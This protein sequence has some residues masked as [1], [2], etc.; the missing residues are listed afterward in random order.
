MSLV[1]GLAALLLCC[2]PPMQFL[3]GASAIITAILSRKERFSVKAR[4]ALILGSISIL[5]SIIVFTQY[6][7]AMRLMSDPANAA[8]VKEVTRYYEEI[9][10]SFQTQ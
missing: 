4:I 2:A 1:F 5:C 8:L 7:V 6:I 9:L 3:L 10:N